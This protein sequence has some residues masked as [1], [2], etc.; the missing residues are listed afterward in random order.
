[1]SITYPFLFLIVAGIVL[2]TYYSKRYN[3]VFKNEL[4]TPLIVHTVNPLD[5]TID[6]NSIDSLESAKSLSPITPLLTEPVAYTQ[7]IIDNM[8]HSQLVTEARKI[9]NEYT[10]NNSSISIPTIHIDD[11]MIRDTVDETDYNYKKL[12]DTEPHM[13]QSN[14]SNLRD[15]I[16]SQVL[17]MRDSMV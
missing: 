3:R 10:F 13:E 5:T 6:T 11:S 14:I 9:A 15:S 12:D 1:M 16:T 17:N 4:D 8:T 2:Y 7:S